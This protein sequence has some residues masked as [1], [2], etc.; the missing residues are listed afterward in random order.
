MTA[1]R[2]EPGQ[3]QPTMIINPYPALARMRANRPV[4][5][6][7]TAEG[8]PVWIITSY[9]HAR[10]ALTDPR[11]R[12][13]AVRAQAL[14]DERVAGVNLGADVVH[15]LNSDPPDHT[16]LRRL[17]QGS[18]TPKR[19]AALR[20]AITRIAG[21]LLDDIE[22]SGDTEVDLIARFALPLPLLVIC[23]LLGVPAEDRAAYRRWST[24]ILTMDEADG[25]GRAVT[26]MKAYLVDLFARKEPAEDMLTDLLRARDGG[27]L[28]DDEIV[29]MVYLLLIG[30]HETTVNLIGT[31]TLAL[32]RNPDQL[33]WLRGNPAAMPS[34]VEE[35]LRYEPP[36]SIATLRWTTEEVTLGDV[37]IGAG[38]FV[39]ISLGAANRDPDR[40]AEPDQLR[41]DRSDRGHLA[42]GHGVHRCLGAPLGK[43]EG[44]LAIT[45]LLDRFP[46][47][48]LAGDGPRL[49]WRNTPMLRGLEL[50]PVL[51]Y[52]HRDPA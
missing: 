10:T 19:V 15:M 4:T 8:L 48:A 17:I 52:G 46:R 18:F 43:L 40:F 5:L 34:V 16:R 29:A 3:T 45:A 21:G 44:E 42:F 49:R 38:E 13:G 32:L 37:H 11:F 47:L 39:L 7:R 20:P 27:A 51:P 12:Q 14:A 30:G 6:T 33:A 36:V 9:E 50:L 26:E 1:L 41:L 23:E 35:F 31:A 25:H 24:E 22:A 28:T 2:Q